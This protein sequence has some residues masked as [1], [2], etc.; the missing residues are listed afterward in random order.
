MNRLHHL[1][2]CKDF[3]LCWPVH[4]H[5]HVCMEDRDGCQVCS[6][7]LFLMPSSQCLTL[8]LKLTDLVRMLARSLGGLPPLVSLSCFTSVGTDHC[9][10][11]IADTET[12]IWP[13]SLSVLKLDNLS[14]SSTHSVT[15]HRCVFMLCDA[16]RF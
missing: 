3:Q 8:A 11:A 7:A 10:S 14:V 2:K 1:G 6:I 12:W 16:H 13:C 15:V 5:V 4:V 9:S